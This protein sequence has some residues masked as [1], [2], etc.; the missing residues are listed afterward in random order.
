MNTLFLTIGPPTVKPLNSL[1]R[2]GG[3][4]R[5]LGSQITGF[6]LTLVRVFKTELFSLP[7][8]LPCQ[9]LVPDLVMMFTTE[10]ALRPYSGPNWLV[11]RT[12]CCTNSV[13]LTNSD[14]PPTLLSL[15]FC[16]SS[17]WSLLRPRSPLLEKPGPLEFEK[18]LSRVLV[19]PGTKRA[20]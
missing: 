10:P 5:Q 18:V 9:L 7:K 19:I 3:P 12:Y 11:T 13:L 2:R 6:L 1:L 15:L 16:P 17:S 20:R 14:G 8:M 4:L